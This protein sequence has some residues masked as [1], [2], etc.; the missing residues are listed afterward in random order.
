MSRTSSI[1]KGSSTET[2]DA[3]FDHCT[4]SPASR[5]RHKIMCFSSAVSADTW[6]KNMKYFAPFTDQILRT[7][8]WS[9]NPK[10]WQHWSRGW[11]KS[12]LQW[13]DLDSEAGGR[14]MERNTRRRWRH[15]LPQQRCSNN[16]AC[17]QNNDGTFQSCDCSGTG[18]KGP[19]C[20]TGEIICFLPHVLMPCDVGFRNTW[21]IA[22][23]IVKLCALFCKHK[24]TPFEGFYN[25]MN[26]LIYFSL[27]LI[28]A[29]L[30]CGADNSPCLNGATCLELEVGQSC[31]CVAGFTGQ[32]CQTGVRLLSLR[33]SQH[34][35]SVISLR[36]LVIRM[37]FIFEFRA[38]WL[39]SIQ[40]HR[41]SIGGVC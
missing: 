30:S 6:I 25:S 36:R 16:G 24:S 14:S 5:L 1:E 15:L 35:V 29:A 13:R 10:P 7:F 31:S 32:Q 19:T 11:W 41:W 21:L 17:I 2:P 40:R 28:F 23:K 39:G 3:T 27:C 4:P 12:W 22:S 33:P 8:Q 20:A 9:G 37:Y 34:S 38:T 18:F 26:G